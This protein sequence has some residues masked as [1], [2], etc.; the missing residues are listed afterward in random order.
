MKNLLVLPALTLALG[1]AACGGGEKNEAVVN[2]AVLLNA[3]EGVVTG[4]DA[5][6]APGNAIELG[7][8]SDT[9]TGNATGNAL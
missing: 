1:L 7:N 9:G 4:N 3:D 8:F 6:V 2:D 5:I